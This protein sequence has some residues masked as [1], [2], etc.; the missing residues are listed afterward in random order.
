MA[1][2]KVS[3]ELLPTF[4]EFS[5]KSDKYK[6]GECESKWSGFGASNDGVGI[7]SLIAWAKEDNPAQAKTLLRTYQE[8]RPKKRRFSMDLIS[9]AD[10]HTKIEPIVFLIDGVLVA[11]QP[12][13]TVAPPKSMKTCVTVDMAVSLASGKRFLGY[14]NVNRPVNVAMLSGE[15]GLPVIN[16][17]IGRICTQKGISPDGLNNLF[18]SK[19][20][21]DLGD[22]EVI[23]EIGRCIKQ[24]SLSV[25]IIDPLYFALAGADGGSLYKMAEKLRPIAKLC[26]AKNVTLVLVHHTRKRQEKSEKNKPTELNDASLAG[27]TEFARQ[28]ITLGRRSRYIEGTGQHE[29][30]LTVGGSAGHSGL[31]KLDI[32]EGSHSALQGRKWEVAIS[33]ASQGLS[34]DRHK[35]DEEKD[36]PRILE[37]LE[38]NEKG[39]T[40]NAMAEKLKI[41]K[42]RVKKICDRLVE[43]EKLEA[44]KIDKGK[45]GNH[46]GYR[47]KISDQSNACQSPVEVDLPSSAVVDS[48]SDSSEK[49]SAAHIYSKLTSRDRQALLN[50][51]IDLRSC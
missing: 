20:V 30:W 37:F 29:L 47:L 21:P 28:W 7:G 9:A 32:K 1:L 16:E 4:R 12:L 33:D 49:P 38:K 42:S 8:R 5:Q 2:H 15:S 24:H 27:I 44:V 45:G 14:F 35:N 48:R 3:D 51:G 19:I 31:Y 50:N 13:V 39:E 10:L 41:A 26:E 43:D 36:E 22:K 18:I 23:K 6:K 40:A 11:S 46:D 17:T 34:I 25:I